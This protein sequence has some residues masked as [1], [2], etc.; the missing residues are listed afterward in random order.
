MLDQISQDIKEAM[1]AKDAGRLGTL[2]MLKSRLLENK[3]SGKPR[4]ELDV[5][6]GYHKML[7]D[8]LATFPEASEQQSKVRQEM[9]YLVPYLPKQLEEA[10]VKKMIEAILSADSGAN[11]GQIMKALSPQIKGQFDGKVASQL[12]KGMLPEK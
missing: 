5:V 2:R 8:S 12:V 9:E 11:F 7:K 10:D 4:P 3:T 1:K 6:I